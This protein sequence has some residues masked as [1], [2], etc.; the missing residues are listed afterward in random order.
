MT[1]FQ[2]RIDGIVLTLMSLVNAMRWQMDISGEA[3]NTFGRLANS[4]LNMKL[5]LS[6]TKG[7]NK[8]D[9]METKYGN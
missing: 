4:R 2:S 3:A 1:L 8:P 5:V 9:D 7:I 6:T